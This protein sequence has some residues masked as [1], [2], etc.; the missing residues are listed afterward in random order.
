MY[1]RTTSR[2][3]DRVFAH[4]QILDKVSSGQPSPAASSAVRPSCRPPLPL[5][6]CCEASLSGGPVVLWC[7]RCG[8]QVHASQLDREVPAPQAPAGSDGRWA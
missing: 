4:Q 3:V 2:L 7:G 5:S 8:H 1:D 6:P